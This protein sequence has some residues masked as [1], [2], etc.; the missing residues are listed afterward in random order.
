MALIVINECANLLDGRASDRHITERL[1][2][3]F[4]LA[5]ISSGCHAKQ[6][7]P[8]DTEQTITD[9][10]TSAKHYINIKTFL[11]YEL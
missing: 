3:R 5:L 6:S 9:Y 11:N 4:Q 1:P 2:D 7:K 10:N 8:A